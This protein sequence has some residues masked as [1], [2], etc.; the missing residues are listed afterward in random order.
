MNM[1]T[2]WKIRLDLYPVTHHIHSCSRASCEKNS[3]I[4]VAWQ[5]PPVL[6]VWHPFLTLR[7]MLLMILREWE[8]P[9]LAVFGV[10][11]YAVCAFVGLF[12]KSLLQATVCANRTN[13]YS[14][15]FSFSTLSQPQVASCYPQQIAINYRSCI[16]IAG[17]N[18]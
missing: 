17:N 3:I 14:G 6:P 7:F 12:P 18:K 10:S 9:F 1:A 5:A 16:D 13:L 8:T 15:K 4:P 2:G 11:L